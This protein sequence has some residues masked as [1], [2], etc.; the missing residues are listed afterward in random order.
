MS[1]KSKDLI[2]ASL[3]GISAGCING[4]LGG[5]GG[6]ILIPALRLLTNV[7]ERDLFDISVSVM[8]PVCLISLFLTSRSTPLP[9]KD[10]VPYLIGSTLGGILSGIFGKRIPELWLHRILGAM[11]LWGG[12]RYLC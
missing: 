9:W 5:A 6:L 8:L 4:I 11:I 10:A 7:K 1:E 2:G 12:I 3:A